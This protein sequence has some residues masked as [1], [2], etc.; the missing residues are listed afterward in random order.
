MIYHHHCLIH[1]H[2]ADKVAAVR[3]QRG[4]KKSRSKSKGDAE[5]EDGD[6]DGDADAGNQE[7]ALPAV[8]KQA[9]SQTLQWG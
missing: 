2:M 4:K 9:P 1:N 8:Q 7:I 5:A 6:G 3:L